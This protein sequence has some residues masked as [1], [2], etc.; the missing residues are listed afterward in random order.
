MKPTSAAKAKE[1]PG[2]TKK[3]AD[4]GECPDSHLSNQ[5]MDRVL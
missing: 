4:T 5:K 3:R 2:E 1:R